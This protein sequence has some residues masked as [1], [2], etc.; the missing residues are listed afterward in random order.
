MPDV[1]TSTDDREEAMA[2]AMIDREQVADV[3]HEYAP[4]HRMSEAALVA[5]QDPEQDAFIAR[6]EE[7]ARR[8]A[9]RATSRCWRRSTA[10]R[11]S[12][13]CK[14]GVHPRSPGSPLRFPRRT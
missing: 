14:A 1:A 8:R 6:H 9:G 4:R 3:I 7:A 11:R 2:L 13:C 10:S 12:G 5:G